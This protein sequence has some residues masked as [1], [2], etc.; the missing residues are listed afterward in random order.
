[1][2]ADLHCHSNCSDGK[3]APSALPEYALKAGAELFALTDHDTMCGIDEAREAARKVGIGFLEGVEISS[4]YGC[5]VHVLGYRVDGSRLVFKDFEKKI[6]DSRTE[7][8]K[9]MVTRLNRNGVNITFEDVA[10]HALR[11]PSRIHVAQAMVCAGYEKTVQDCFANWL[12]EGA[13][14]YVPNDMLTPF[15]AVE[16]I[17]KCGGI[18]VLA[19]PM[20]LKLELSEGE[21]LVAALKE[22]G[23]MGIEA[24]YKKFDTDV[25]APFYDMAEKYDLF[26]TNGGD[27]HAPDRSTFVPRE[28]DERTVLALGLTK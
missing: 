3:L 22:V 7:R 8:I 23:L 26:V 5:N 27:F 14:C 24:S 11:N 25:C 12:K 10:A 9:E 13:P 15:E 18:P 6:A 21:K 2:I 19:H 1:M 28:L 4:Y 17:L 20:R 16:L